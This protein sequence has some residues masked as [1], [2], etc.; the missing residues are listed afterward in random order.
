[1]SAI[2]ENAGLNGPLL[3]VGVVMYLGWTLAYVLV[4]LQGFREK[5][6]GV[7]MA[8]IPL[9][10]TRECLFTFNL[11]T[12]LP[13]FFR[14]GN[15]L[16]FGFDLLIIYQLFRF[17]RQNQTQP[18]VQQHFYP[19]LLGTCLLS[20]VGLPLWIHYFQDYMGVASSMS[21][22]LVMSVLFIGMALRRTDLRGLSE[23]VAWS[24]MIGTAAGSILLYFWWPAR[25]VDGVLPGHPD[26]HG[27]RPQ[28]FMVFLYVSIFLVDFVYVLVLRNRKAALNSCRSPED[29]PLVEPA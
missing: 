8:S 16:W 18:W 10:V 26:L 9:N 28:G 20:F 13:L 22:N 29:K 27:P 7:P 14:L 2:L 12:Q 24:K 4:I 25:F 11:V 15:A 23:A 21:M 19:I 3:L 5:S 17:G 6:Y 1:M